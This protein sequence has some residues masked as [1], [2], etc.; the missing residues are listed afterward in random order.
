MNLDLRDQTQLYLG[1]FERETYP[2]LIRLSRRIRT[3]VDIGAAEGE[4]TLFFL[5]KTKA[6]EVYA[7]E[8]DANCL[9]IL[10]EN[11]ELNNM[12]QSQRLEMSTKF[13]GDSEDGQQIRLDSLVGSIHSPCLIKMDVDGAEEYI[14]RGAKMLNALPDIR[15]LIETHSQQL[16]TAC[17]RI[18]SLAGFHIRIIRNAPW[19]VTIPEL[20]P[21]PHNRWLAGWKNA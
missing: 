13:V 19:R 15:W 9:R 16:E 2:W 8:P 11:L 4:Y 14:L 20:R 1:L 10:N 17:E 5:T 7:F 12:A 18:L 21:I 6:T 3:A